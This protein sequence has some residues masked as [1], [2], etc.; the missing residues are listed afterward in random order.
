MITKLRLGMIK[1]LALETMV[2]KSHLRDLK[3]EVGNSTIKN[4]YE[5]ILAVYNA[6]RRSQLVKGEGQ[7]AKIQSSKI[8]M[9]IKE[10]R[11]VVENI[12]LE[13]LD[14]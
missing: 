11:K 3:A 2:D 10:L 14:V 13:G 7:A 8:E 9:E 12:D 5:A 1:F 6:Q 4:L